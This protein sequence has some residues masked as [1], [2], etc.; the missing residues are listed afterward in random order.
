VVID[1]VPACDEMTKIVAGVGDGR[2]DD[3][4]PC[5]DF[6]VRDL[7]QHVDLV[8]VGSVATARKETEEA[9]P[10]PLDLGAGW[11]E[12]VAEH[13][14]ELAAVWAEPATWEGTSSGAGIALPN[15]LWGKI[16]FTEVV[17]HGWDLARATGQGFALPEASVRACWEHV[18]EF[19]PGAPIAGLWGPP[20]EV[21]GDAPLI[22]RIV[23][24]TGRR[25]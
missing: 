22:D 1:F 19:V 23:A 20:V 2:L 10:D 7:L 4:T 12:R 21:A 8:A 18:A 15:E 13:L 24:L 9:A 25:P 5:A 3:A 11:R 17:V 6:R 14:R 16:A